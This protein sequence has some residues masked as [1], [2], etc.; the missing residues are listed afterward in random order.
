MLITPAGPLPPNTFC[1]FHANVSGGTAPYHYQWKI[2]NSNIGTDSEWLGYS[3]GTN[4][5]RVQ[6]FVTD[7]ASGAANDSKIIS[8]SSGFSC[9]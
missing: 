7:A 2:N 8:V 1:H 6:V 3:T 9:S 4:A 5:F